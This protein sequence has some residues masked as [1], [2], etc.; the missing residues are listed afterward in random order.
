MPR[1]PTGNFGFSTPGRAP[2]VNYASAAPIGTALE[3]IGRQ[4]QQDQ[5]LLAR[6]K[7]SNGLDAYRQTITQKTKDIG[8]RI[9]RGELN[10]T[11]AHATFAE[12]TQDLELPSADGVDP[13]TAENLGA[14][15]KATQAAGLS[16]IDGITDRAQRADF[17]NQ[18]VI[19]LD[20]LGKDAGQPGADITTINGK[21]DAFAPLAK[22]AGVPQQQIDTALQNFKDRN[23]LNQATQRAMQSRQDMNGL[24]ALEHDL[25]AADGMYAGKLDTQ[26]RNSV[27]NAVIGHRIALENALEHEAD[28]HEARGERALLQMD[29]QIAS[30]TPATADMWVE[31]AKDVKGTP[32]AAEFD[33]RIA[34]EREVQ[35]V[36]RKPLDEQLKFVADKEVALKSGGGTLA[37]AQNVARLS[38]AVKQNITLMQQ[39]PLVYNAERTGIEV[40]P[41]D[42]TQLLQPDGVDQVAKDMNSRAITL[43][44]M[45]KQ[46]GD[47]VPLRPLLPEEAKVMGSMLE[48]ASP[49]E[50]AQFF[51]TLFE[52]TGSPDIY[53]S[54]MQQLAP[55][56]P[57]KALA[58]LIASKPLDITTQHNTWRADVTAPAAQVAATMLAGEQLLNRSKGTKAEDGKPSTKDL[59]LP[60]AK[61]LQQSF[62]AQVGSAFAGRPSAAE[63]AFQA[64]QAYY[65][66]KAAQTGRLASQASDID[67][68]IVKEAIT[69]TLGAGV[70]YNGNGTV[71]APWG[72]D[73]GTFEDRVEESFAMELKRRGMT[74]NFNSLLPSLGL[75]NAGDGMYYLVQGHNFMTD[76]QGRPIVLNV[77]EASEPTAAAAATR[78]G[79]P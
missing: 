6:A 78:R 69:S 26:A 28:R 9:D 47:V 45:R 51:G 40:K 49:D 35:Q 38:N 76:L 41:I 7:A 52:A 5:L 32:A 22:A 66:G 10:Y 64:V 16:A 1:I 37:Q 24:K 31:W 44:A 77:N 57:V 72:M 48:K 18:F 25:V 34:D 15:V 19:K 53:K 75:R 20:L 46:Y 61:A 43:D 4:K 68:D 50:A 8:D 29:R 59:Y 21:A 30:G 14:G 70:D 13:I 54:A 56:A 3:Q 23:W 36:L 39:A 12:E 73:R 71:L 33:Q 11:D 74:A 65:V 62:T 2:S 27:L 63:N 55:D 42:L 58:G 79:T 17:Q 60:E 67:S